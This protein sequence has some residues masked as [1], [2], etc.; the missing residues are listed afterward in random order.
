MDVKNKRVR[1][2]NVWK[3]D[4]LDWFDSQAKEVVVMVVKQVD[5]LED[6]SFGQY[7]RMTVRY[8]DGR[9]P[10]DIAY[11]CPKNQLVTVRREK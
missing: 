8:K 4:E 1:A 5:V 9:E 11:R 3:G 10:V 6:P 7:V 2:Y